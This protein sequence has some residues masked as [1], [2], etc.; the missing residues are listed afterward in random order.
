MFGRKK[1]LPRWGWD[2]LLRVGYLTLNRRK[3]TNTKFFNTGSGWICV[4]FDAQN[5]VVGIEVI[6]Q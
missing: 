1:S 3:I 2:R 5:K 6:D 4:D